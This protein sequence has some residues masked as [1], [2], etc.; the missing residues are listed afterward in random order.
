MRTGMIRKG[1]LVVGVLGCALQIASADVVCGWNFNEFEALLCSFWCVTNAR[2][3]ARTHGRR[4][5]RPSATR[6]TRLAHIPCAGV[7]PPLQ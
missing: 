1:C 4:T 6:S 3:D 7:A 2:T 5:S